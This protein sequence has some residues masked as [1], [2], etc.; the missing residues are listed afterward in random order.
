MR[1]GEIIHIEKLIGFDLQAYTPETFSSACLNACLLNEA[2]KLHKLSL[3][4][5]KTKDLSFLSAFK[6]LEELYLDDV[7]VYTFSESGF[8][9]N[10][11]TP[12]PFA[13]YLPK[14]RTLS[15][16]KNM[17]SEEDIAV[18]LQNATQ[19]EVLNV[20]DNSL[21]N[22]DFAGKLPYLRELYVGKNSLPKYFIFGGLSRLETLD[23]STNNLSKLDLFDLPALQKLH[24]HQNS[25]QHFSTKNCAHFDQATTSGAHHNL[26]AIE[27][28]DFT[29]KYVENLELE[30]LPILRKVNISSVKLKKLTISGCLQFEKLTIS[31][32]KEAE[33]RLK[34]LPALREVDLSYT[35]LQSI[36]INNCPQL[37]KLKLA[38]TELKEILLHDLPVLREVDVFQNNLQNIR[39]NNCPQLENL[40]L[41]Q[42]KLLEVILSDLP[43]LR[44]IDVADS[45]LQSLVIQK[46]PQLKDV[47]I[48]K[49]PI[50]KIV[51][52]DSFALDNLDVSHCDLCDIPMDWLINALEEIAQIIQYEPFTN[53]LQVSIANRQGN[54]FFEFLIARKM[55][56][57]IFTNPTLGKILSQKTP[58][59][60]N[61]S[62]IL[63]GVLSQLVSGKER[64]YAENTAELLAYLRQ[65][66]IQ[67]I[68]VEGNYL[69]QELDKTNTDA[70][71]FTPRT[72]HFFYGLKKGYAFQARGT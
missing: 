40:F 7:Y 49:T 58:F 15:L 25:L 17:F 33:V 3:D 44:K 32:N 30:N 63:M 48:A 51:F 27:I 23:L 71:L 28:L 66:K 45:P 47:Y 22:L 35:N 72:E 46:C 20:S 70:A 36:S 39:I 53:A 21:H 10:F 69:L 29:D 6:D 19:V 34:N 4:R 68:N 11:I 31:D 13:Q 14:L 54:Y 50:R 57:K 56:D 41:V 64:I 52:D 62:V 67:K 65:C 16:K 43:A 60:D 9:N 1:T 38:H 26:L 55:R 12:F 18:F 37:E 24:L 8:G 5:V 61:K 2:G 59:E 42:G